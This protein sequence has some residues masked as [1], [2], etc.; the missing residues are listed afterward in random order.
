MS[1][2]VADRP[3]A[4]PPASRR[5]GQNH[6]VDQGTLRAIMSLAGVEPADVALEIGAAD[7]VLTR[8]LLAQAR[9]VHAFEV[10][11]RFDPLLASLARAQPSLSVHMADALRSD[12]ADLRPAPT[13]LVA[14]LAYNIAIPV[15][16]KSV[17]ELP[18]VHR[19]AVMVQ[20]ELGE[21]LF[22]PPATKAYSAVSVL[23]QLACRRVARR[24]VP[25]TVFSPR[26]RVDSEFV[27]FVRRTD[28]DA[29]VRP[30]GADEAARV[31]A[32]VRAAF[33]QRRKLLS[34]SLAGSALAGV[35][36]ADAPKPQHA[37]PSRAAG[38]VLTAAAVRSAL[39]R[40][41]LGEKARPQELE[42]EQFVLL[43]R[44]L[45]GGP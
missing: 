13:I 41:G 3:A 16:V 27:V 12:L 45:S 6:L 37:P 28:E 40:I 8:P 35:A 30:C 32:V 33:G 1:A 34:S 21:R 26:P 19:W 18:T 38:P 44:A 11:R 7:G 20:K 36:L 24:A 14:N 9:H 42:P 31:A 22:A 39:A 17:T 29:A 25:R 5:Y 10:D 2:V 4:R 23:V 15:I 43:T